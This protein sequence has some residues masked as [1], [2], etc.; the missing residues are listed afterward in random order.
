MNGN[1]VLPLSVRDPVDSPSDVTGTRRTAV[2]PPAG[3]P[4]RPGSI[5][6]GGVVDFAPILESICRHRPTLRAVLG[7]AELVRTEVGTFEL[8]VY[9]G[10]TFHQRQLAEKPVRDL[11]HAEITKAVGDGARITTHVKEGPPP[12]ALTAAPATDRPGG[13]YRSGRVTAVK[14]WSRSDHVVQEILRRYDGEIVE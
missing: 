2:K 4:V 7:H 3:E 12:A 1:P 13:R 9:N 5:P 11:I 8:N 10:S 14:S 6:P